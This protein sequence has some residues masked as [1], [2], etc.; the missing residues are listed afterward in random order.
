MRWEYILD[1]IPVYC[2]THFHT[3]FHNDSHLCQVNVAN[4]PTGLVLE[5]VYMDTGRTLC[6]PVILG[7]V[8]SGWIEGF[9]FAHFSALDIFS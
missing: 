4:P 1:E 7:K 6:T 5:A 9:S 8:C 3:H 2:R